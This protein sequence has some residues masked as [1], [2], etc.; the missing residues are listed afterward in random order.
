[1]KFQ[2]F[3][4]ILL[5]VLSSSLLFLLVYFEKIKANSVYWLIPIWGIILFFVFRLWEMNKVKFVLLLHII[6]LLFGAFSFLTYQIFKKLSSITPLSS[7][8]FTNVSNLI[9]N[10]ENALYLMI[11]GGFFLLLFDS[12]YFLKY[13]KR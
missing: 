12:I 5:I 13:L 8:N 9:F 6:V 11:Y 2:A 4:A 7:S 1:M 10:S 3:T